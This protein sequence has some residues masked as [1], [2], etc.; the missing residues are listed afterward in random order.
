MTACQ[1]L[2]ELLAQPTGVVAIECEAEGEEGRE[3]EDDL[4][5]VEQDLVDWMGDLEVGEIDR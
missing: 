5:G 4:L 1:Q 2:P 3:V